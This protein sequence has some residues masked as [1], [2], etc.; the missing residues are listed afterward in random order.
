MIIDPCP[1]H[2]RAVWI[3]DVHLG[4]KDC[5][6]DLLLEFLRSM[7]CDNLY[8]VGDI[9]DGWRLKSGWYWP[10]PH[11]DVVQKVLRKARKGT[12]VVYVPGNHDEFA[13]QYVGNSFGAVEVMKEAIHETADGRSLLVLH[14]DEFDCVVCNARWLAVLGDY[15]YT[16][17]LRAN[18]WFDWVRRFLGYPYWSLSSYLKY[19]VKNAVKFIADYEGVVMEA[20]RI[21]GVDGVICGHIHHAEY[22]EDNGFIYGNAG[23]WVESCTALVEHADGRM[24]VVHW[25]RQQTALFSTPVMQPCTS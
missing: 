14:G 3:S 4:T 6:A 19:K 17:A 11:N 10:Q 2:Y 8:L 22:R 12:R 20:A 23:D 1:K 13:R 9:I 16:L 24:E 5:K 21:R 7:E 18:L 25:P 15:A